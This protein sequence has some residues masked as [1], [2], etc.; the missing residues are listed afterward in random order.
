VREERRR[1]LDEEKQMRNPTVVSPTLEEME[2][3]EASWHEQQP[4]R[5]YD[6]DR[7]DAL[8]QDAQRR[9]ESQVKHSEGTAEVTPLALARL[10]ARRVFFL[11]FCSSR[12]L[13]KGS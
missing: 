1:R 12:F 8:Y 9:R 13:Q 11:S 6:P 4:S 3:A 5:K 7:T 2:A 10:P